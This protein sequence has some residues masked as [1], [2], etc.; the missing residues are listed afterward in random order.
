[1]KLLRWIPLLFAFPLGA[2]QLTC[3][4]YATDS[5]FPRDKTY[6]GA[7]YRYLPRTDCCYYPAVE[8]VTEP[9]SLTVG[10]ADVTIE[11]VSFRD[12]KGTTYKP[13]VPILDSNGW[14]A[15]YSP[16]NIP[17]QATVTATAKYRLTPADGKIKTGTNTF[18]RVDLVRIS[19]GTAVG[20][21]LSSILNND[22]GIKISAGTI[23]YQTPNQHS[24]GDISTDAPDGIPLVLP[25][26]PP[27]GSLRANIFWSGPTGTTMSRKIGTA[28]SINI[29]KGT[30]TEVNTAG[31]SLQLDLKASKT[32]SPGA[33]NGSLTLTL[34]C[35]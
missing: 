13:A 26:P 29:P 17:S 12:D 7:N 35:P 1:M 34:T 6:S 33:V 23:S 8:V 21:G 32:A 4:S 19:G 10:I 30:N 2:A 31:Q 18:S 20:Q 24:F 3:Q 9:V 15:W 22:K 28:A 27:T 16:T 11:S 25:A 14:A 5:G